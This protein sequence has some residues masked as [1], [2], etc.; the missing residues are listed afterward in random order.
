MP[1]AIRPAGTVK[2]GSRAPGRVHPVNATPRERVRSLAR[3]ARAWT[4]ARD[5][6]SSVAA[7]ATLN[8][9]RSPA[10]PRRLCFSAREALETSSVTAMLT[11]SMP[12]AR[13]RSWAWVKCRTSPA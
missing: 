4:W 6:P 11:H 3:T 8:T 7:P 10:M 2:S 12:S 9:V 5:R 13:R 1:T